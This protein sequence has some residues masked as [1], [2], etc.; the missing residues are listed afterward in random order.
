MTK[1]SRF[2]TPL[3]TALLA[4]GLGACG[5]D[6]GSAGEPNAPNSPNT[7]NV[8]DDKA[9][10]AF[11]KCLREH[12]VEVSD[13]DASGR[14]QIR[15][16]KK[17]GE[18][19]GM[20][21]RKLQQATKDCRKKTGGGPPEPTEEQKTEMRDQ[22]LKFAKC[23]REHG[24]DMPDPQFEGGGAM[25]T[26]AGGKS[27]KGGGIDPE[28]PAF[29]KASEACEDLL[30]RLRTGDDGG[31]STSTGGKGEGA[32]SGGVGADIEVPAP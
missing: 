5:G 10:L 16:S 30:P 8:A 18:E 27:G 4:A 13:P 23:M 11:A 32:G 31:P 20:T 1:T 29:Q 24:I 26:R 12:G 28:S 9:Q 14:I 17:P 3:L 21:P 19:G 15:M 7:E 6:N 25:I 22:A 2:L